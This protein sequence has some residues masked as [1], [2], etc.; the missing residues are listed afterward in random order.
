LTCYAAYVTFSG[1][2]SLVTAIL[3][4]ASFDLAPVDVLDELQTV[5]KNVPLRTGFTPR[6]T[7]AALWLT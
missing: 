4:I 2:L 6:N 5:P 3:V 7:S 1:L